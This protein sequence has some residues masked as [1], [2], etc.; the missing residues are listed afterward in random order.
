MPKVGDIY[1]KHLA[2]KCAASI[3]EQIQEE[4]NKKIIREEILDPVYNYFTMKMYPLFAI[5]FV[6]ILFVTIV[7]VGLFIMIRGS[8]C[9]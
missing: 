2:N 8:S 5:F 7:N 4:E 9:L 6:F 3:V 1:L